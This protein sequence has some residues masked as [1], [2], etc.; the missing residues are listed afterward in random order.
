[1]SNYFKEISISLGQVQDLYVAGGRD[2]HT[3]IYL[4]KDT[5]FGQ[6]IHFTS[7]AVRGLDKWEKETRKLLNLRF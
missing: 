1:M 2:I 4:R 6:T 7:A 3:K 5:Q